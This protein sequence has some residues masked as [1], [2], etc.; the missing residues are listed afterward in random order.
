MKHFP[1]VTMRIGISTGGGDCPG[2][3]AIIRAFVK[4]AIRK[5]KIQ[6][7]GIEDSLDGLVDRP[8]RIRPLSEKDVRG[9]LD[10]GGTILGTSNRGSP[11]KAADGGAA[12]R[13]RITEA[14]AENKLDGLIMIGGD[15]TQGMAMVMARELGIPLIGIPKTIDNDFGATQLSVGFMTAVDV[16]ADAVARLQ[17][18]A[19][20]HDRI[21]VVEVMGR[22]AGFIALNAGIAGGAHI[23]LIPEIPY[24]YDAL[25]RKIEERKKDG[26]QFCV[27]VVA[28][29]AHEKGSAPQFRTSATGSTHL[30]GIG[31]VVAR[32][33][34]QRT[35]VATRV[36]VLGHIQ[37]GGSP[38]PM[39]RIL[40]TA[41]GT[42]AANLAAEKKFGR[43]VCL[44]QGSVSDI[45][46]DDVTR[47]ATPLNP[48]SYMV[49]AAESVGICL[50]R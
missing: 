27:V 5:H 10:R 24:D 15:G 41:F 25:I 47:G 34:Y 33:L 44:N 1:E 43:I 42:H 17:S 20:A 49:Q 3:N 48:N 36:T 11:F 31:D 21:M 37:R 26:R 19:E 18:T 35:G 22:S 8:T 45:S 13:A 40:A 28:E 16:A 38:N 39:D 7:Y 14:W 2:L 50:G 32:E 9:I 12:V 46:Y 4:C 29:G 30:G 6:V 23:I